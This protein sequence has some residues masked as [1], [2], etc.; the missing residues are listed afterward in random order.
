LAF[1]S[2]AAIADDKTAKKKWIQLFNGKNLDGWKPKIT[3]YELN[4]NFGNTF[5]VEDGVMKVGY[6]KYDKFDNKFGHIFYEQPFSHYIVRVE[7]RFTGD[8]VP[9]GPGWAIRNSGIMVHGQSAES[10]EKDQKFPVS[11]EVQLLGGNG[12][13]NRTTANLCTPGT[14]VVMNGKLHKPHC[15]GSKSKTYHGEQWVTVEVEVRGSESIKHIVN[16]ETVMV[17][18]QPQYDEGSAKKFAKDG[19]KL[20]SS[21][22]ISLQSE[23]HPV[24]FRKVELLP[25]DP[26]AKSAAAPAP[27]EGILAPG[28]KVELLAD[29]FKFTEGPACDKDGNVYFTDQPNDRIVK[30]SVDGKRSTFMK[31]CGRSNG[32]CFD[33]GGN[34]WACAD[35]KNQLWCIAPNGDKEVVIKE[36]DGALLNGPNDI[37]I[38]PKGGIYFTD[39]FYKRPYW[40][41]GPSEQDGQCVYY[42]STDRKLARAAEGLTQPNGIIGTPDGKRL[43][44]ADIRAKK[45]YSYDIGADGSLSGKKL[46][47]EMGSDGMTI[48]N[49]GNVYLTGKGVTVFDPSGKK[50]Q[51]IPIDAGWTANVCFGGKDR[52]TLFITAMHGLFA[53][54]TRV[55]GVGSQ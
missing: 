49:E 19:N 17:Y 28:A 14:H 21:G 54:A 44:V 4:D 22:S 2:A 15:T 27:A 11:I 52:R 29:G 31:P 8:Q 51:N 36:F 55:Q 39:P 25:L 46:F 3:G 6:D 32:L 42:L 16:G 13:D 10:M 9:G 41:R 33:A 35:E 48:D 12:K 18:H 20:I 24:E 1:V 26:D 5:R 47:C 38:H 50:I 43:Y 7:Y 45:T 30:W 40:K 53:V 34:L 37:W 23:S